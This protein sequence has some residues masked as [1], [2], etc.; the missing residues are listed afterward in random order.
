MVIGLGP[1]HQHRFGAWIGWVGSQGGL[2]R[3]GCVIADRIN[4]T[5][6]V[7]IVDRVLHKACADQVFLAPRN[8]PDIPFCR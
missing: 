3:R 2:C 6:R 4:F 5:M 7:W 1:D 8:Q